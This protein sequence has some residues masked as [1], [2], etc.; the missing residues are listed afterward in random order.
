M[1]VSINLCL[2][3]ILLIAFFH[4][5][6]SQTSTVYSKGSNPYLIAHNNDICNLDADCKGKNKNCLNGQCIQICNES[7]D[8]EFT[9]CNGKVLYTSSDQTTRSINTSNSNLGQYLAG[10]RCSWLL[11][12]LD[13]GKFKDLT[14]NPLVYEFPPFIQLEVH[15]FSTNFGNDYL[16]IFD[17][18][19]VYSPLIAAIS[20]EAVSTPDPVT[21]NTHILTNKAYAIDFFNTSNIFLLFKSDIYSYVFYFCYQNFLFLFKRSSFKT[22]RK[23]YV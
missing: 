18:D 21:V 15:E 16:Y 5:A 17:G 9:H 19:S 8:C 12:N 11:R 22:I 1:P 13:S 3:I 20:G 23:L 6:L 4:H 7:T 14:L 10:K 2:F